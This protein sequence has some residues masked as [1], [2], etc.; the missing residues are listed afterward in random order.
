MS[1]FNDENETVRQTLERV[2]REK[3]M[4]KEPE[5]M[6]TE[7]GDFH[8][9]TTTTIMPQPAK[10]ILPIVLVNLHIP[11]TRS[12]NRAAIFKTTI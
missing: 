8:F 6:H 7:I 9:I 2:M 5:V 3:G 1:Y 11:T 4:W 12:D 10:A